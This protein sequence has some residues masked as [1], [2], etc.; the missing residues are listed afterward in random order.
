MVSHSHLTFRCFGN[1]VNSLGWDDI[2]RV[3]SAETWDKPHLVGP[4]LFR[5]PRHQ[6]SQWKIPVNVS[7]LQAHE[8]QRRVAN[9]FHGHHY[10]HSIQAVK[11]KVLRERGRCRELMVQNRLSVQNDGDVTEQTLAGSTFSKPLSTPKTLV[12][13]SF[14]DSPGAAE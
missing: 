9:L 3:G 8:L 6:V 12:W 4:F 5:Q 2:R 1:V 14:W 11:S 13:T 10:L 7:F